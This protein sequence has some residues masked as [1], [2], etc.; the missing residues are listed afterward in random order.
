[1]PQ[2]FLPP[3]LGLLEGVIGEGFHEEHVHAVNR[4]AVGACFPGIGIFAAW[5][6]SAHGLPA[7]YF[8]PVGQQAQGE[9]GKRAVAVAVQFIGVVP[10]AVF[11]GFANDAVGRVLAGDHYGFLQGIGFLPQY[12]AQRRGGHFLEI[13]APGGKSYISKGER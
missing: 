8:V 3:A 13:N 6:R 11:Y 9:F 1:M 12:D 10:V 7:C 4:R 2:H 5:I